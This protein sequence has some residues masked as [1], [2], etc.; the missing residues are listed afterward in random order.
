MH[1]INITSVRG[2]NN[3]C[4]MEY[5]KSGGH[6]DAVC[7]HVTKRTCWKW[8]SVAMEE[9]WT[10]PIKYRLSTAVFRCA[11][12]QCHVVKAAAPPCREDPWNFLR[13]TF[14][15]TCNKHY[16]KRPAQMNG[17]HGAIVKV[18]SCNSNQPLA[19]FLWHFQSW[20]LII[21]L[22]CSYPCLLE[23]RRGIKWVLL[24]LPY[25]ILGRVLSK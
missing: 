5:S 17:T 21:T 19:L 25:T 3:A 20:L 24:H 15:N 2:K 12:Q 23:S 13:S 1:N 9:S 16:Y 10:C 11:T 14:G 22:P 6:C 4:L 8:N 18:S 7:K